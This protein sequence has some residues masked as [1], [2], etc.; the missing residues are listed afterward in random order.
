MV[1]SKYSKTSLSI[2]HLLCIGMVAVSCARKT[3]SIASQINNIDTLAQTSPIEDTTGLLIDSAELEIWLTDKQNSFIFTNDHIYKAVQNPTIDSLIEV[4]QRDTNLIEILNTYW[5]KSDR[6]IGRKLSEIG[7]IY[8]IWANGCA[9]LSGGMKKSLTSDTNN[10][11]IIDQ[12]MKTVNAP[13]PF[14]VFFNKD[15]TQ[16]LLAIEY[17]KHNKHYYSEYQIG[18]LNEEI[19]NELKDYATIIDDEKFETGSDFC[20]GITKEEVIKENGRNY[21]ENGDTI[22][23]FL[24]GWM[25]KEY[26]FNYKQLPEYRFEFIFQEDRI[27]QMRYGY[28]RP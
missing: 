23:Y 8:E 4:H 22:T 18:Y 9:L 24:N 16:Y 2:I 28:P 13:P 20:L 15:K 11:K 14:Y 17:D 27:F 3:E 5:E 12:K 7:V 26:H 19:A 21:K 6:E 10:I 1:I 25:F